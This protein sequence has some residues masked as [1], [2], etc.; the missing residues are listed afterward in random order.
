[1]QHWY[2]GCPGRNAQW[3]RESPE[4]ANSHGSVFHSTVRRAYDPPWQD[5]LAADH[6]S[7]K[8]LK[9]TEFAIAGLQQK[10]LNCHLNGQL[11]G[12]KIITD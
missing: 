10:N 1:M 11:C 3:L 4:T 9:H 12:I 2:T 7:Q 8:S 5:L 6:S